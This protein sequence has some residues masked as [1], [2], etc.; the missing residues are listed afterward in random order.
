ML[1]EMSTYLQPTG[2]NASTKLSKQKTHPLLQDL[3]CHLLGGPTPAGGASPYELFN[4]LLVSNLAA[5][6][7]VGCAL[8]LQQTRRHSRTA[9]GSA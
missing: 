2:S 9:D 7:V 1:S 8:Q 4:Q 6:D 3:A 5:V